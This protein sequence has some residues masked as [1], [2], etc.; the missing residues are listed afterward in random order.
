MEHF[1]IVV[2]SFYLT[3]LLIGMV[4]GTNEFRYTTHKNISVGRSMNTSMCGVFAL[5]EDGQTFHISSDGY[6]INPPCS[7]YLAGV[8]RVNSTYRFSGMCFKMSDI[9]LPCD[10]NDTIII[11]GWSLD[12]RYQ[13]QSV[14]LY[15]NQSMLITEKTLRC[16]NKQDFTMNYE[17]CGEKVSMLEILFYSRNKHFSVLPKTTVHTRAI[18]VSMYPALSLHAMDTMSIQ[19]S[20]C[21]CDDPNCRTCKP[22]AHDMY[23]EFLDRVITIGRNNNNNNNDKD[24]D[25]DKQNIGEKSSS[26]IVDLNILL[27]SLFGSMATLGGAIIG[28][29]TCRNKGRKAEDK[30]TFKRLSTH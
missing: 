29:I 8:N 22:T 12:I 20:Q 30:V 4:G 19:M 17:F 16:D 6:H 2:T 5:T 15:I 9:A 7:I 1:I 14:S 11:R 26:A 28:A 23:I 3:G 10:K 25:A 27:P 21:R 24:N 18:M 13:N